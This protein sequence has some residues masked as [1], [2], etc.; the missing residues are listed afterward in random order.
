MARSQRHRFP[1][2]VAEYGGSKRVI[3]MVCSMGL[4]MAVML[5][6]VQSLSLSTTSLHSTLAFVRHRRGSR[7]RRSSSSSSKT[8]SS[9]PQVR[10]LVKFQ[11]LPVSRSPSFLMAVGKVEEVDDPTT[12]CEDVYADLIESHPLDDT[13]PQSLSKMFPDPEMPVS[14]S[15]STATLKILRHRPSK[16]N[17]YN[18]PEDSVAEWEWYY[19]L[20]QEQQQS[21]LN[22]SSTNNNIFGGDMGGVKES[23]LRNWMASQRKSFMKTLGVLDLGDKANW[24]T[25]YM[26]LERKKRLDQAGFYWGHLQLESDKMDDIIFS[27]DFQRTVRLRYKDW[28]WSP[29]CDRLAAYQERHHGSTRVPLNETSGLGVWTSEQRILR[30]KMPERRR[31][32]LDGLH[33]DWDWQEEGNPPTTTTTV[34]QNDTSSAPIPTI[35]ISTTGT[36]VRWG[37]RVKQLKEYRQQFGDCNVPLNYTG[38]PAG[39]E[40]WVA[41]T[42]Q[43]KRKLSIRSVIQLE[44]VGFQFAAD[45][46]D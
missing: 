39:L 40:E 1:G 21:L 29:M 26:T 24:G 8:D 3:L 2:H 18:I 19:K 32:R 23:L 15:S 22:S 28:R 27:N 37:T 36:D 31:Q 9:S 7:K 43:K 34:F 38:E 41:R 5:G 13:E 6:P 14:S 4:M 44:K 35:P 12:V 16:S 17:P 30:T 45:E 33:F 46:E 25:E 20:L 11:C 42:K 10:R